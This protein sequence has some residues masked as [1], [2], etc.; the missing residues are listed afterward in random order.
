MLEDLDLSAIH[1]ENARELIQRLLNLVE[2]LAADLRDAQAENQRLRDENNHLKGEQGK[3]QVKGNVKAR[4]SQESF[5][6]EERQVKRQRHSGARRRRSRWTGSRSCG[7]RQRRCQG[8]RSSRD[9][10]MFVVQDILLKT[11]N[12]RFLE[13]KYYSPSQ[14]KTYQARVPRGYEGGFGRE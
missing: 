13:E 3:P 6:G 1:E 10:R 11:D 2:Q 12:V 7:W 5:I 14:K 9:I 8:M 4:E